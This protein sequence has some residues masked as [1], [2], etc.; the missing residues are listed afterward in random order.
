VNY[1]NDSK[2]TNVAAAVASIQS[3]NGMIVLIAGGDGKGGDFTELATALDGKLRAAVLIGKDAEAIADAIDTVMP[4][5]FA[6]DMDDAVCRAAAYA[7][8][9][10]TVLLAPACASLDQYEN[11]AARGSAFA[12]AVEA[13]AR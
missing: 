4:V 9:D 11:Y 2:A 7:E 8:S 13:L 3:I 10:D 5:Y 12:T 6:R 1:I